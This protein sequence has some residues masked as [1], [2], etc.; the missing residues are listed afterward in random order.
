MKS[1]K[2]VK[3]TYLIGLLFWLSAIIYFFAANWGGLSHV[4]QVTLACLLMV[5]FYGVGYGFAKWR[6]DL[7]DVG[8]WIFWGG[9]IAFGSAVALIGQIYNSHADGYTFF[10]LWL[11]PSILLAIVTR[12]SVFFVQSFILFNITIYTYFYPLDRWV[13]RTSGEDTAITIGLLLV[14]AAIMFLFASRKPMLV[15]YLAAVLVQG[16]AI[17]VTTDWSWRYLYSDETFSIIGILVYVLIA[18]LYAGIYV[19]YLVKTENK[20]LIVLASL[21]AAILLIS[22]FFM[23]ASWISGLLVYLLG[24]LLG[25]G[26]IAGGSVWVARLARQ[27]SAENRWLHQLIKA[28]SIFLAVLLITSSVLSIFYLLNLYGAEWIL[29]SALVLV[30]IGSH[31]ERSHSILRYTLM[32]S[33]LAIASAVLWDFSIPVLAVYVILVSYVLWRERGRAV[34]PFMLIAFLY[35]AGLT[36][37]RL[38]P[39]L[40]ADYILLIL[41]VLALGLYLL[42]EEP[43]AKGWNL[44]AALTVW[45]VLTFFSEHTVL[46]YLSN[47]TYIGFLL[48]KTYKTAESRRHWLEYAVFAFLIAY[49]GY[50][51]Y[52]LFWKLLHKS[53][54]FALAGAVFF[55]VALYFDK[56]QLRMDTGESRFI[57]DG[58]RKWVP[59]VLLQLLIIGAIIMQKEI[60]LR[61]GTE[62]TLEVEP[63]DPRSLMQGDY[64]DLAYNISTYDA[65]HNYGRV[66]VLLEKDEA[67]ISQIKNIYDNMDEAREQLSGSKEVIL[68]GELSG[69]RI[70]YGI[71]SF[72]IEEGTG[73][74]LEENAAYAKVKVGS[75]GDAILLELT[76]K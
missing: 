29:L 18:F 33:G 2:A 67:G 10:L 49:F 55:L 74:W 60:I 66:Y 51:Y 32:L 68:Q 16:F 37:L 6:P 22:H 59:I 58:V 62:I 72:F 25:I 44:I 9:S 14:N 39:D 26:L 65:N 15:A 30:P 45:F 4:S 24:I 48:Y 57:L 20:V 56:R 28:V 64:V 63:V 71:E 19:Q 54:T 61:N 40:S 3:T 46:Y 11:I 53:V 21:G 12:F 34:Y 73:T 70:T 42:L 38:L 35:G 27:S 5:L 36:I 43:F 76:G 17:E 1:V 8:A 52:D 23:I 69:D 50:K 47:I 41:T 13:E 31:L 75:N 7:A